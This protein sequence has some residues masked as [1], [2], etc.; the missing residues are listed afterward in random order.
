LDVRKLKEDNQGDILP[1]AS[2]Y[3]IKDY[4]LFNHYIEG[5]TQ[6][7][8]KIR[9]SVTD[10]DEAIEAFKNQ[11]EYLDNIADDEK[12]AC[13]YLNAQESGWQLSEA[14]YQYFKKYGFSAN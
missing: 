3:K 4:R 13:V 10:H 7:G 14:E 12:R 2:I 11:Q 6:D 9:I 5:N 1:N 8:T